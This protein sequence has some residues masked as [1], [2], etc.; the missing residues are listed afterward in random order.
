MSD[1]LAIEVIRLRHRLR[2]LST[3]PRTEEHDEAGR[4]LARFGALS[5]SL[6][7]PDL[8]FE[9]QRW[10]VQFDQLGL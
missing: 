10:R 1:E 6:A 4:T 7:D 2:A 3:S 8:L 9:L 5:E